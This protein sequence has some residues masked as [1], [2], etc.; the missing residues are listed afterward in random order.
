[1]R[2]VGIFLLTFLAATS[3]WA[4]TETCQGI[5]ANSNSVAVVIS[6]ASPVFTAPYQVDI[7][8]Q[9][10]SVYS[11]NLTPLPG[12]SGIND[13][14]LDDEGNLRMNFW[15]IGDN[16]LFLDVNEAQYNTLPVHCIT[17]L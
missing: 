2:R 14:H 12:I 13:R 11:A 8:I 15:L 4:T 1:M 7:T 5:D 16:S 3:A 17:Q 10:L 9:G 6:S